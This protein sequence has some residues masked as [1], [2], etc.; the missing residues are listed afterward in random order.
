MMSQLLERGFKAISPD[1]IKVLTAFNAHLIAAVEA[2]NPWHGAA[3]FWQKLTTNWPAE[4]NPIAIPF[5]LWGRIP[6]AGLEAFLLPLS[7]PE[8]AASALAGYGM[9]LFLV[10]TVSTCLDREL[11]FVLGIAGTIFVGGLCLW[12]LKP[13]MLVATALSGQLLGTVTGGPAIL[14]STEVAMLVAFCKHI[15]D[16][17]V[18]ATFEKV[19]TPRTP[20]PVPPLRGVTDL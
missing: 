6:G 15:L 19:L 18:E 5:F 14:A 11:N 10:W 3:L 1:T 17:H 7:T 20:R 8:T 12:V 9:G 4:L 16:K 2:I 13:I